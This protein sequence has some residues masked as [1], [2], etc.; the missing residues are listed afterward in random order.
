MFCRTSGIMARGVQDL[1]IPGSR[2]ERRHWVDDYKNFL[3]PHI[4]H[5]FHIPK[6]WNL[7][8]LHCTEVQAD[9]CCQDCG[10]AGP[11]C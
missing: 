9:A 11:G 2:R 8:H 6:I 1:A 4:F 5:I 7:C 3:G 10:K